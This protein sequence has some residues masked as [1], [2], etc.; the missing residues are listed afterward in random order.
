MGRLLLAAILLSTFGGIA[1]AGPTRK[2]SVDTEPP[3]ASIYLDDVDKAPICQETPCTFSSPLGKHTVIARLDK[4]EPDFMEIDVTRNKKAQELKFKLKSALGTIVVD[5][6]KGAA[7]RVDEEDAGK[8]P[9][10]VAVSSAE[11]HHVRVSLNGKVLFDDFVDVATGDEFVV[12]GKGGGA[13]T[14]VAAQTNTEEETEENTNKSSEEKI[15]KKASG[16]SPSQFITIAAIVDIGFRNF[17]YEMPSDPD[18]M[19][20]ESEYGQTLVGPAVEFFPGRLAGIHV[21]RGLS[22]FGRAQFT[23][24]SQNITG[25]GLSGATKTSW[26]TWEVSLRQL[27][28]WQSF[29]FEV[30]GGYVSDSFSFTGPPDELVLL[31]AAEYQSLRLGAKLLYD[32]GTVEPYIAAENRIVFTGGTIKERFTNARANGIRAAAGLNVKLW[33]RIWARLEGALMAYGWEFT[34]DTTKMYSAKS[35]S[36]SVKLISILAAFTY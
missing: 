10:R 27:W 9:T 23:A 12:K 15:E 18:L 32:A 13:A 5:T 11:G 1:F 16:T 19:R 2:V 28:R 3:G 20:P 6:P 25:D 17:S 36:D 14:T 29:G 7:V 22:L 26:L 21:L 30:G 35:A 4:Y 33:P 34:P 24:F 8:A 31:P